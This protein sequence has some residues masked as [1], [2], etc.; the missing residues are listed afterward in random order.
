MKT[1]VC[2]MCVSLLR[3]LFS[4]AFSLFSVEFRYKLTNLYQVYKGIGFKY[5]I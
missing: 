4:V 5:D 1:N 3:K 2:L